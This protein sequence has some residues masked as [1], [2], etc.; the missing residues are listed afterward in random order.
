MVRDPT[1]LARS[2]AR[3]IAAVVAFA[4]LM[5]GGCGVKG[6]L[7]LPPGSA[8]PATTAPSTEAHPPAGAAPAQAPAEAPA[9]PPAPPDVRKP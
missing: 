2:T 7:K 6:P 4:A 9:A 1:P 3:A 5:L 8:P